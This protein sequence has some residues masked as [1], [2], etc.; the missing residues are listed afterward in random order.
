M[1]FICIVEFKYQKLINH[2]LKLVSWPSIVIESTYSYRQ[3][4]SLAACQ[5]LSLWFIFYKN[6]NRGM[7]EF[8]NFQQETQH[9]FSFSNKEKKHQYFSMTSSNLILILNC[10]KIIFYISNISISPQNYKFLFHISGI[11]FQY[12]AYKFKPFTLTKK[13]N[14]M[15]KFANNLKINLEAKVILYD[16]K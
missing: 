4:I 7:H 8:V 10:L 11:Q 1:L 2:V 3:F 15:S 16:D 12:H 6:R 9:L 5:A 14:V 13:K